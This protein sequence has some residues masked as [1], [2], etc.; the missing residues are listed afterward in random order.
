MGAKNYRSFKPPGWIVD[1]LTAV[2][3]G[4]R[5]KRREGSPDFREKT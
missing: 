2:P 5:G 3:A 1:Q 4:P